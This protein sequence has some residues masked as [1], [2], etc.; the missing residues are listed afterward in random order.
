MDP[1]DRNNRAMMFMNNMD[2]EIRN[3]DLDYLVERRTVIR[4]L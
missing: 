4:S 1:N 3:N 2:S